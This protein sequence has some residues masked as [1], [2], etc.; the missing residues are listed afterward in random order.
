MAGILLLIKK[1]SGTTNT[2]PRR[3]DSG[4]HF[5]SSYSRVIL[6]GLLARGPLRQSQQTGWPG[7][8]RR[9]LINRQ[10]KHQ[11]SS[12]SFLKL[13]PRRSCRQKAIRLPPRHGFPKALCNSLFE[14]YLNISRRKINLSRGLSGE[15]RCVACLTALTKE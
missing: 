10:G 6:R 2:R 12:S 8:V 9:K 5:S 13:L 11:V 3:A 4:P 15:R 14:G 7:R 1:H